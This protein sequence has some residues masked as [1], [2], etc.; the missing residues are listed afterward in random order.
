MKTRLVALALGALASTT[1]CEPAAPPETYVLHHA[2]SADERGAFAK[3]EEKLESF[4]GA[5]RGHGAAVPLAKLHVVIAPPPDRPRAEALQAL[6]GPAFP[7]ELAALPARVRA[8][9]AV[10]DLEDLARD[11]GC[12]FPPL[13][14]SLMALPPTIP[15]AALPEIKESV[16]ETI[17]E[18]ED[19]TRPI[20]D[21]P[22]E[23]ASGGLAPGGACAFAAFG[24]SS[25]LTKRA[26]PFLQADIVLHEVGHVLHG[27]LWA[28]EGELP[29]ERLSR[30]LNEALAD[31]FAHAYLGDPCHNRL[32]APD[33]DTGDEC[34]RRMD[35]HERALN[36][37]ILADPDP[38]HSNEALR[39]LLWEARVEVGFDRFAPAL[40]AATRA[41]RTTLAATTLPY[42]AAQIEDDTF[43][44]LLERVRRDTRAAAA[45]SQAF[46]GRLAAS[47][48]A[49]LP[50]YVGA[51]LDAVF[52]ELEQNAPTIVGEA[53]RRVTVDGADAH[54]RFVRDEAG[55]AAILT[56]EGHSER[57]EVGGATYEYDPAFTVVQR[58]ERRL[59]EGT[60]RFTWS[61]RGEAG[62]TRL[63]PVRR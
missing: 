57:Y 27:A 28:E 23:S 20:P 13:L 14:A 19:P 17:A 58:F 26:H 8:A 22:G 37:A 49:R 45:F 59:P 52:A 38:H 25:D 31:L 61:S 5:W 42:P 6:Y 15:E 50:A 3:V 10:R 63:P 47:V 54:V 7:G 11:F 55:Y 60:E 56:R 30:P 43:L 24:R 39:H 46:C 1:G 36:Q 34:R 41:I 29:P 12:R 33:P 40:V 44:E 4:V 51:P 62:L 2:L 9:G 18:I 53:G 21:F 16:L 35:G 48:C 32:P